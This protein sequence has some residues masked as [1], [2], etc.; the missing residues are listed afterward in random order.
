MLELRRLDTGVVLRWKV[1]DDINVANLSTATV[2]QVNFKR[3]DSTTFAKP[4]SFETDG[5]DGVVMYVVE[6]G[7]LSMSGVYTWQLY[8]EIPPY[9]GR[10]DRGEI[11]VEEII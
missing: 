3:P 10:S 4:L 11:L 8:I 6:D 2:K 5:S 1:Y 9:K 7:V